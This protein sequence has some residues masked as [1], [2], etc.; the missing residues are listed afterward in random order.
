MI[1]SSLVAIA[2]MVF[3]NHDT[4]EDYVIICY[5]IIRSASIVLNLLAI[6]LIFLK[7]SLMHKSHAAAQANVPAQVSHAEV[8]TTTSN[9]SNHS[10]NY[11]S[12]RS[13]SSHDTVYSSRDPSGGDDNRA[14]LTTQQIIS[15]VRSESTTN[16]TLSSSPFVPV[17]TLLPKP[18]PPPAPAGSSPNSNPVFLL[19]KRLV[20]YCIVQTVARIG[21]SWYQLA[22]GFGD[23]K[24]ISDLIFCIAVVKLSS[25]TL[26][27][28][29]RVRRKRGFH[30]PNC[31]LPE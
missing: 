31:Y 8:V 21:S 26:I 30:S 17:P 20:Y 13:R 9:H 22:Y 4:Y 29:C 1:P 15:N 14:Q 5:F 3:F 23:G 11:Q 10:S 27:A 24:C 12:R 16:R 19:S 28:R 6:A 7:I 2:T 25:T 18:P